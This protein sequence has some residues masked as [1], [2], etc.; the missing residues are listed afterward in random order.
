[1]RTA[2]SLNAS[3]AGEV[4]FNE[5][6]QLAKGIQVACADVSLPVKASELI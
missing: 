2:F 4:K 1:M 3:A 5:M 6:G